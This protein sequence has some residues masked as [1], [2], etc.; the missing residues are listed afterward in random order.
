[1]ARRRAF[2]RG[3]CQQIQV[4]VPVV[5]LGNLTVGGTGKT[6]L[7]DWFI[8]MLLERGRRPGVV[9]RSY[10]AELK[11]PEKVDPNRPAA[12]GRYGDEAVWIASRHP[13]VPVYAG[14]SKSHSAQLLVAKEKVDCLLVDDGF[15]HFRLR[16]TVDFVVVD[17]TESLENYQPMP[18]GRARE[19]WAALQRANAIILSKSNQATSDQLQSLRQR[20]PAGIPQIVFGTWGGDLR[21]ARAGKQLGP[22]S[23]LFLV[24]GLARPQSFRNLM[25]EKFPGKDLKELRFAD[26]HPYDEGDV[27]KIRQA[28]AGALVVTTEKDAVK[29]APLWPANEA[30]AILPL[31]VRP[32]EGV[33]KI[34]VLLDQALR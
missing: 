26:H 25:E 21:E 18:R 10:R 20:L 12:A 15:Q 16:R 34:N 19:P 14:P 2:E 5:S 1:M 27:R 24:S 4:S 28:A 22:I 29:L 30:L 33:E 3:W 23:S 17:A 7:T 9:S 13:S 6:P 32:M 31:E 11:G 8:R